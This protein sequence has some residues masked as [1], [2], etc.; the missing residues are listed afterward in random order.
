MVIDH[1]T[2]EVYYNHV[3]LLRMRNINFL[4]YTYSTYVYVFEY[5][6][7]HSQK[8]FITVFCRLYNLKIDTRNIL[9]FFSLSL[10][11]L[12]FDFLLH[13]Y[14]PCTCNKSKNL[15]SRVLYNSKFDGSKTGESW[16]ESLVFNKRITII[17]SLK[18]NYS[19][20]ELH[21]EFT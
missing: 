13:S 4:V 15:P 19:N 5:V 17:S 21:T 2:L 3:S 9:F 12:H 14:P 10:L 11:L 16:F 8:Q 7:N 1:Y 6:H 18:I 20:M